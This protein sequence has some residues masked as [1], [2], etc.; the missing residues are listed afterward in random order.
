MMRTLWIDAKVCCT[1]LTPE[2]LLQPVMCRIN[3]A[4]SLPLGHRLGATAP[5]CRTYDPLRPR[6]LGPGGARVAT[7]GPSARS[8]GSGL[9]HT[10]ARDRCLAWRT[11]AGAV[12][13]G[14]EHLLLWWHHFLWVGPAFRGSGRT[15]TKV[16]AL[17]EAGRQHSGFGGSHRLTVQALTLSQGPG[18]CQ[19]ATRSM[20]QQ[21]LR[22]M[23]ELY[24]TSA[25]ERT[26]SAFKVPLV[27]Y[28]IAS[29]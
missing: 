25:I 13:P 4:H 23:R 11:R 12:L 3:Y 1:E 16:A 6:C 10:T 20:Q 2:G 29:R 21:H 28:K 9:P 7:T 24:I 8:N 26:G 19:P 5:D 15:G 14:T 18:P 22:D 17:Q 27:R